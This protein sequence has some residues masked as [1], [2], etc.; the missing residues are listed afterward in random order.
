MMIKLDFSFIIPAKNEETAITLCI[1]SILNQDYPQSSEI[2]VIDDYSKDNTVQ[3]A[4]ELGAIVLTPVS[5]SGKTSRAENK[6]L[7]VNASTGKFLIFLDAHIIL[8][9]VD[10]LSQ[11]AS[12]VVEN[13]KKGLFLASFPTV[14]PPELTLLLKI[15]SKDDVKT[16]TLALANIC[17]PDQ[18]VGGSMVIPRDAFINLARFP[19]IPV[20]EDIGLYK[21]AKKKQANY[22]FISNLWVWHLD[23]K[24]E[25]SRAWLKRLMKEGYYSTARSWGYSDTIGKVF[26]LLLGV[27]IVS[28]FFFNLFWIT[29]VFLISIIF[30]L[31]LRRGLKVQKVAQGRLSVLHITTLITIEFIQ[32]LILRLCALG[33]IPKMLWLKL[34]SPSRRSK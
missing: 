9:T 26:S 31:Q 30:L 11:V 19:L 22:Q 24:L 27:S 7:A 12:I 25:S 28:I 4:R 2:I 13:S 10:W 8:P 33:G 3:V 20:S 21:N 18:F 34:K 5:A 14:P 1:K 16:I 15:F 23:K 17:G 32:A 29:T 6:N